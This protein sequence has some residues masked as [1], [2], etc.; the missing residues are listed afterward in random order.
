MIDAV[1]DQAS[2][3]RLTWKEQRKAWLSVAELSCE[4]P[5]RSLGRRV[6]LGF[7][8]LYR[9]GFEDG[10]TPRRGV[11]DD[12]AVSVA[13]RFPCGWPLAQV[14]RWT[15]S[16]GLD[17][18]AGGHLVSASDLCVAAREGPPALV[19]AMCRARS[20]AGCAHISLEAA[21]DLLLPKARGE[22]LER[23]A[24]RGEAVWPTDS[25]LPVLE[26]LAA[27]KRA[28]ASRLVR[29]GGLP[30]PVGAL[31]AR[32]RDLAGRAWERFLR[33][34]L[35]EAFRRLDLQGSAG[36]G[37]KGSKEGGGAPAKRKRGS[38]KRRGRAGASSS[39]SS[40]DSADVFIRKV[41]GMDAGW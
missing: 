7:D 27:G 36:D 37:A 14:M 31:L 19:L 4:E 8:V 16:A 29:D 39:A 3:A 20:P 21:K 23:P 35:E 26:A 15:L 25:S 32:R 30:L 40:V 12:V 33:E 28:V 41:S 34:E 22:G 24:G 13:M 5:G 6:A 9:L 38:Q 1:V 18:E 2:S 10:S 11:L 17:E